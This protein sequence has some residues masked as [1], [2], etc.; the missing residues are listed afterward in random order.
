MIM[1]R[2]LLTQ[3]FKDSLTSKEGAGSDLRQTA[4]M[5]NYVYVLG[6]G[7]IDVDHLVS[8]VLWCIENGTNLYRED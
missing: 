4:L 8:D 1:D 3:I 6:D 7:S 5:E 2:E